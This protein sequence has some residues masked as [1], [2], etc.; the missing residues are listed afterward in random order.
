[1]SFDQRDGNCAIDTETFAE[2][3]PEAQPKNRT[4]IFM[5]LGMSY[6]L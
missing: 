4:S 2:D 6:F 1:V 3:F 5:Q